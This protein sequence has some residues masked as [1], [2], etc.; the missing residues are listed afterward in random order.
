MLHVCEDFGREFKVT[1][2]EKKSVCIHF[3]K[4]KTTVPKLILNDVALEWQDNVRHLG[5]FLCYNLSD[6]VDILRKRGDFLYCVNNLLANFGSL[7]S[8]T[9]NALFVN[10]CCSFYG[11]QTWS[12]YSNAIDRLSTMYNKCIRRVWRLPHMSHKNV[13]FSLSGHKPLMDLIVKR[14]KKLYASMSCVNNHIVNFVVNRA[15]HDCTSI[16]GLNWRYVESYVETSYSYEY[17]D[18]LRELIACRDGLIV[19][20]EF[21]LSMVN[22]MVNLLST[23][24]S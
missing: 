15:K 17:V 10:Y 23:M 19:L 9:L 1:Y 16:I 24:D 11:C 6:D 18:T 20:P 3:C 4:K 22:E 7:S 21:P 14:C 13:V 12:L 2:N 5:M 8:D